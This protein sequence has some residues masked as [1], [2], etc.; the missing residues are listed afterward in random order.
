[1]TNKKRMK[2][3][4]F[5]SGFCGAALILCAT[6]AAHTSFAEEAVS[7][8]KIVID[9]GDCDVR[10]L[11]KGQA[12][13]SYPV[14]D[15]TATDESGNIVSDVK[16]TV[17]SPSGEILPQKGGRFETAEV[18]EYKI[19]YEAIGGVASATETVKIKVEA[20]TD[21]LQYNST[22]ENIQSR[23]VTGSVVF[24]LF[25][26][27]AG[28]VGDLIESTVLKFG[29]EELPLKQSEK[30]SYFIPEKR[31]EYTITYTATDFIGDEKYEE[32][33]VS[34]EDSDIPVLAK[35]SLPAS[36]IEGETM[37]FP[38][39]DGVL[40][41]NGAKYYLPVK[42]TFDGTDV[43]DLM[44]VEN[45]VTGEHTIVYECV[46]PAEPT[47]KAIHS[48]QL[49]VKSKL[50]DEQKKA[51]ARLFD[52]YFDFENCKPF[53]SNARE[54]G[55]KIG[56]GTEK[57]KFSFS[58]ELPLAYL[59][60]DIGT[61][62]GPAKYGE[63]NCVITDSKWAEDCVIV[64]I[65]RLN[66]YKSLWISYDEEKKSIVDADTGTILVTIESYADGRA[67]EGF[68]SGKAY[69]SFEVSRVRNDIDFTLKRVGS[70]VI[71]TDSIDYAS[72]T[73]LPNSE[74]KAL[75]VAYI[76]HTVIFPK[77]EA[78]DLLDK[79]VTVKLKI[80]DG[81]GNTVYE[82]DGGYALKIEKSGEYA[83]EYT[84]RDSNGNR[85]TQLSTIYVADIEAP[86][87]TVSGI[88]ANVKVG[89]E[90]SLPAA[91]I[92]DN[93]TPAEEITSYIYVLKGNNRKQLIEGTYKFTE[94]GE[95]KIRYVAF[96]AY[97][98]YTVVEFTVHCK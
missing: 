35:A 62:S 78:F 31:G 49:T 24:A 58:R 19:E 97:Q 38:L 64:K 79:N 52:N 85:K 95:Y 16:I 6:A 88:K 46:N 82:G 15:C 59:N 30:G 92:T 69:I 77:M 91:E 71:T 80:T 57:A 93:A 73:F 1:M 28:G 13:K 14:F 40:Y 68:K 65:K 48:F 60:F 11:P 84:V 74:Y 90:I 83:A 94:A 10:D 36:A 12:G 41:K 45:P 32:R 22:G 25:G 87:I 66:T 18:G 7:S 26:K 70:N 98:N 47:K 51:G 37:E 54:Y 4:I 67:F 63:I 44:R 20:Y 9:Y 53:T 43:S 42:T 34:V 55:V 96:D 50:T 86:Q 2:K 61:T 72:P 17:K 39:C 89:E 27:Y 33:T 3:T 23:A 8:V 5:I 56:A 76:G 21:S 75:G 29:E 81:E